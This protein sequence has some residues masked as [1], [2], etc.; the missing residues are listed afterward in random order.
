VVA[1]DLKGW[2]KY[3]PMDVSFEELGL[4]VLTTKPAP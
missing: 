1:F 2:E 3:P 4:G